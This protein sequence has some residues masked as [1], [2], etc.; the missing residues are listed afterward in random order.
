MNQLAQATLA[1]QEQV[2]SDFFPSRAEI[3]RARQEQR[4][5]LKAQMHAYAM[6]WNEAKENGSKLP[7]VKE[8]VVGI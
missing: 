1:A 2:A 6:A 3:L 7:H 4:R 5:I 8:Y